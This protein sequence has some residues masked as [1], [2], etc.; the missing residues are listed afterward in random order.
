MGGGEDSHRRPFFSRGDTKKRRAESFLWKHVARIGVRVEMASGWHSAMSPFPPPTST[1]FDY[2]LLP[3]S[4]RF[5]VLAR[6]IASSH[7][8]PQHPPT[9]P[10]GV[11]R[12]P[13]SA[14]RPLRPSPTWVARRGCE[15]A[16]NAEIPPPRQLRS[17]V[18]KPNISGWKTH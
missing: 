4:H 15:G 12:Q 18:L 14:S 1:P 9:P 10:S 16:D 7:N 6:A 8:P 17:V 2:L 11:P 3:R 13:H 5:L